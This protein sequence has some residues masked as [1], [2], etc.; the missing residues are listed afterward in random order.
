MRRRTCRQRP[1][2]PAATKAPSREARAQ[3]TILRVN[4]VPLNPRTLHSARTAASQ[5][6]SARTSCP[7]ACRSDI[8]PRKRFRILGCYYPGY[9]IFILCWTRTQP[10]S[11]LV[12]QAPSAGASCQAAC[13]SDISPRKLFR[14]LGCC[15]PNIKYLFYVGPETRQD[16]C[17]STASSIS[18]RQLPSSLQVCVLSFWPT[19]RLS[20]SWG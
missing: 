11:V 9:K 20:T 12:P 18:G 19:G 2:E 16:K 15:Y 14:V 4:R 8:S 13:R 5:A 1:P 10:T 6:L 3:T 7:A 17:F